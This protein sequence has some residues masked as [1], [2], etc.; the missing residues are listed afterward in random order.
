ME[1][2]DVVNEDGLP[3]GEIVSG[4]M[5]IGKASCTGRHMSG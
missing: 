4:N 3:T 5:R 2:L 1:Y